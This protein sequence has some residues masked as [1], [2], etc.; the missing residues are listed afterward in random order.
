MDIVFLSLPIKKIWKN[1]DEYMTN[2]QKLGE[3]FIKNFRKY[4]LEDMEKYGPII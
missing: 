2:L 1:E 3:M 4:N